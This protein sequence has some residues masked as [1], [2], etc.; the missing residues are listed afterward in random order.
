[1]NNPETRQKLETMR[2]HIL[3]NAILEGRHVL[4]QSREKA[5]TWRREEMERLEKEADQILRNARIRADEMRLRQTGAAER[6]RNRQT[7]RSRNHFIHEAAR[8]LG[9]GLDGLRSRK[10]YPAILRGLFGESMEGMT[11]VEEVRIILAAADQSLCDDLIAFA[12]KLYPDI[13]FVTEK[14][15]SPISGGLWLLS[16]DGKRQVNSDWEAKVQELIPVLAE[17]LGPLL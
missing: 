1:M 17:R 10:N 11:G 6:E 16:D 9:E 3:D 12:E 4:E 2:E 15:P 5:D 8:L 14:K 13:R 7:M